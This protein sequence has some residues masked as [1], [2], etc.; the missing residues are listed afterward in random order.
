MSE[1]SSLR[2]FQNGSDVGYFEA[3]AATGEVVNVNERMLRVGGW[4]SKVDVIGKRMQDLFHSDE[5]GGIEALVS[6][7]GAVS[8]VMNASVGGRSGRMLVV[9]Q[10]EAD[11]VVGLMVE[12]GDTPDLRGKLE[13]VVGLSRHLIF[14]KDKDFKYTLVSKTYE[15]LF[16]VPCDRIIGLTDYDFLPAA[17]AERFR[18]GDDAAIRDGQYEAT[19]C[20]G[21]RTLH[22]IKRRIL[23]PEG[24]LIGIAAVI[25][26][27]SQKLGSIDELALDLIESPQIG[28]LSVTLNGTVVGC[29]EAGARMIGSPSA[30]EALGLRSIEKVATD[31]K[32][33]ERLLSSILVD[34]R[35][36]NFELSLR[37]PRGGENQIWVRTSVRAVD[38]GYRAICLDITN[39][40]AQRE[41]HLSIIRSRTSE[42]QKSNDMLFELN[43]MGYR[44]LH[45]KPEWSQI[46]RLLERFG[47]LTA[48]DRAYLFR[49]AARISGGG[50]NY[51]L[52]HEWRRGA[53]VPS[54]F[55]SK[56]SICIN[57]AE[58]KQA[59][60]GG[61]PN[62][63]PWCLEFE[64][65]NP[66]HGVSTEEACTAF[67]FMGGTGSYCMV[68][69]MVEMETERCWGF[70]GF[71]NPGSSRGWG[72]TEVRAVQA[73]ASMV[74]FTAARVQAAEEYDA[75]IGEFRAEINELNGKQE[76][77][78]RRLREL[79]GEPLGA[80]G[81]GVGE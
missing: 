38:G 20:D 76:E 30:R 63:S 46:D 57:C 43:A 39:D 78:L 75:R 73:L 33:F 58:S 18:A 29:N 32:Q 37:G 35:V 23:T 11:K 8:R 14:I 15:R 9:A 70:I 50:C 12:L 17:V 13:A 34:G 5:C 79:R 54:L 69:V 36:D 62:I 74:G 6:G 59:P 3:D 65:G 60:P 80:T 24:E 42:L 16:S 52:K 2:A 55:D 72:P 77:T 45:E 44:L 25:V 67:Q 48:A 53:D 68:P 21:E 10:L 27:L 22:I 66:I 51:L 7:P 64:R 56:A 1:Q 81:E 41:E 47:E 26:D 40:V 28:I 31:Q 61:G 49:R 19:E 4:R 71:D